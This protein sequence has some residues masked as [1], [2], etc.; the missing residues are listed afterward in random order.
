MNRQKIAIACQGGGSQTAFTAGVLKT[1]FDNNI[2]HDKQIVGL[3]GTSGG[4]LNA[5]LAWYGLLK[6]AQGDTTP[7]GKRIADFWE[8][9]MAKEP[10][11]LF[12]TKPRRTLYATS[13]RGCCLVLKSAPPIPGFNGCNRT[14][15]NSCH[16]S[17]SPTSRGCWKTTSDSMKSKVCWTILANCPAILISSTK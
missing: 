6:A 5:A 12:W 14:C 10:L 11:E 4:A 13:A 1:F 3:T 9:L 2:H 15:Q 16:G 8:D 7:I 17:A